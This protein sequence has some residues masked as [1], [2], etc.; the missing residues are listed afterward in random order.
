MT[1]PT[2][3]IAFSQINTELGRSSTQYLSLND[4]SVR[5]MA[6]VPSG[7]IGI[8]ALRGR[9][10]NIAVNAMIVGPGG[11]MRTEG[12]YPHG[13]RGGGAAYE[14][15]STLNLAT[16]YTVIVASF[17]SGGYSYFNG[18]YAYAGTTGGASYI[19]TAD[20]YQD[21]GGQGGSGGTSGN[22]YGGGGGAHVL[23]WDGSTVHGYG[24]G[25]GGGGGSGGSGGSAWTGYP[26]GYYTY[27]GDGGPG[28]AW[29]INGLTYG[30]GQ[31]GN[32]NDT[33]AGNRG[34]AS[35]TTG[36][37]GS[38]YYG[39]GGVK[40]AYLS[41]TPLFSGGTISSYG[42]YIVHTFYSSGTLSPL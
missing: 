27:G 22:G 23:Y 29:S 36:E 21:W 41:G 38:G 15:V 39:N 19:G 20:L 4:S 6:R 17:G 8:S 42:S 11:A 35:P 31:G 5:L 28:T 1:L 37:F 24:Y 34:G 25:S 33:T 16:P 14:A 2:G 9:A 7:Q 30:G 12:Y 18:T 10:F 40:I 32:I 13:G 26:G 3:Q